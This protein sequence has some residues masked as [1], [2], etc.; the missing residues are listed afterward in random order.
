M[1][2]YITLRMLVANA[3]ELKHPLSPRHRAVLVPR[4]HRGLAVGE[5]IRDR[6]G[7]CLADLPTLD[8]AF[9]LTCGI[10]QQ[11]TL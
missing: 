6:G 9:R 1:W 5:G 4:T 11:Q 7:V 2:M 10:D 3:Q 8:I